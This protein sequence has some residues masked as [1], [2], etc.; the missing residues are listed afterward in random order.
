MDLGS[1]INSRNYAQAEQIAYIYAQQGI[2]VKITPIYNQNQGY[3]MPNINPPQNRNM[4]P[5]QNNYPR[6]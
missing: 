6:K 3:G 4:P 1:A 2:K 5:Y